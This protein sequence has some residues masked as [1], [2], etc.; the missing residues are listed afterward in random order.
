MVHLANKRL[1]FG[2]VGHSGTGAYQGSHGFDTLSHKKAMVKKGNW[3][4]IPIR[5]A[6]YKDKINYI[7]KVLK[8]L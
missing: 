1:P 4:D 2:G 8:W 6:P 3:I 5:Y 7:R